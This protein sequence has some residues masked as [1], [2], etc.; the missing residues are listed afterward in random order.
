MVRF[1]YVKYIKMLSFFLVAEALT[2]LIY[3]LPPSKNYSFQF[4]MPCSW[5]LICR[6]HKL[7]A[8]DPSVYLVQWNFSNGS[9]KNVFK[10]ILKTMISLASISQTL[11]NPSQQATIFSV[12]LRPS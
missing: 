2:G 5:S 10:N 7:P 6:L 11:G 4:H 1:F 3:Y 8:V 9:S 12:S